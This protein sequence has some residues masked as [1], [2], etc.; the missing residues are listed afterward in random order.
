M[1][2]R[3]QFE[4]HYAE[5]I[6]A[7]IP[8]IYRHEDG[9]SHRPG[10]L[11][12]LVEILA[13][14][15]AIARRSIDRLLADSRIDE[16]DDW[17]VPYIGGLLGTRLVS[18]LNP[19][20]RRADVGHTIGYRRR[21]GTPRLLETL[22]D[23]IA[24]WDSVAAEA[25]R[26]LARSWHLFDTEVPAGPVSR[27][28]RGGLADL[29]SVRASDLL[30]GPFDDY[31][32]RPDVRRASGTR[33]LYNIPNVNLF[34]YRHY[35][36]P[37]A[38]VT[39]FRLDPTHYALDPSGRDVPL[40][41][42]GA[43]A[44]AECRA[45]R[46][47]EVRAPLTCRRLNA[48]SFRLHDDPAHP[49]AW[50]PLIGRTFRSQAELLDAI[51]GLTPNQQA[52]LV[53]A[54]LTGD[55]PRANLLGGDEPAVELGVGAAADPS[56]EP[57][58]IVGASLGHDW[59]D[60]A[61]TDPWMALL[62]DP[63][64][65]RIRLAGAPGAGEALRVRRAYYGAFWPVGAG[66]HARGSA[67]PPPDPAALQPLAPNWGTIGGNRMF[68]DS[69][70]YAPTASA[71]AITVDDDST[72]WPAD[73]RR[74][75]VTLSP[76]AGQREIRISPDA[77]G[78]SIELN[79]VWLGLLLNGVAA[80]TGLAELV[81]DG[82]WDRIVLRDVTLDPGGERA[83][84]TGA[85]PTEIP[86]VRL[87]VEGVVGEILVE[88]SVIGSI[89][90]RGIA[91]GAPCTAAVLRIADSIVQGFAGE[92]A[93]SVGTAAVELDRVTV[94]GDCHV[95]RADVSQSIIDGELVVEDAQ[96]SCFRFSTARSGGRIPAQ[97]ESVILP[98]GLAA[99]AFVSRRF[100]D[101]GYLQLSETCPPEIAQG[102]ENGT[103][104]GAFN[105]AFGP[106][107]R[108]DLRAK[109]Q[110]YAPVQARVQLRFVT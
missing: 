75:Y 68:G 48:A 5:K 62:L 94:I 25:F 12:A 104:M 91:G 92:P 67:V 57:H 99:D 105:R 43:E 110:E 97:Y 4:R 73:G 86:H 37:L 98:N 49:A 42:P 88:R 76:P 59:A 24:D 50:A 31:A 9:V 26:Q 28:P 64:L 101:P 81:F 85:L 2:A 77:L 19:V 15:A 20:G 61:V 11:R 63:A 87:V 46:E 32:H 108:A 10:Q 102:A 30:D 17:A 41:Q 36:Y 72:I 22:A 66:T 18:P 21:A 27:T 52:A 93:L 95:G 56:L 38:G 51:P 79:G 65:G 107:K 71:G 89:A 83:A 47:W 45:P 55:S 14:Q 80:P 70:T 103:E 74:P 1:V 7:L 35:A 29:R 90:D 53:A 40:Y 44:R 23:D 84:L 13:G 58:E 54:A 33:G 82:Q 3:D 106:I 6:W 78:R 8:A 96:A 34:L 39:P 69:R 60:T 100:G 16:A 109:V